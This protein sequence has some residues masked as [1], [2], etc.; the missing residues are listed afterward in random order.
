MALESDA[1]GTTRVRFEVCGPDVTQI[2]R[3]FPLTFGFDAPI[4]QVAVTTDQAT[5]A[6]TTTTPQHVTVA[7]TRDP[8]APPEGWTL[9]AVIDFVTP[10][11][12]GQLTLG[13]GAVHAI[14]PPPAAPAD[15][16]VVL[17]TRCDEPY[18]A[19]TGTRQ[20]MVR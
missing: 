2:P 5:L 17:G 6:T 10:P 11:G 7:L 9:V 19:A 4:R 12:R 14:P 15:S 20:R 16:V 3:G 13:T 18:A 1:P 8:F